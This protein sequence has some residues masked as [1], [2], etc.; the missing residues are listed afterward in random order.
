MVKRRPGADPARGQRRD[1]NS[2]ASAD[3]DTDATTTIETPC[4][5]ASALALEALEDYGSGDDG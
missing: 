2:D 4:R 1:T 3:T 5:G